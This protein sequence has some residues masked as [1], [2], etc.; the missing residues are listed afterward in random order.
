[1]TSSI[2]SS[3]AEI[4]A[5][6]IRLDPA[7]TFFEKPIAGLPPLKDTLW[8]RLLIHAHLALARETP[9][10]GPLLRLLL[11][12]QG[13]RLSVGE[14]ELGA[15]RHVPRLVARTICMS[16]MKERRQ[17]EVH[18]WF[19]RETSSQ[20][21]LCCDSSSLNSYEPCASSPRSA[22]RVEPKDLV[23]SQT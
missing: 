14:E 15:S 20:V 1:M 8:C 11:R 16:P 19:M 3:A 22:E 9:G 17:L 18:E 13:L 10:L 5:M 4:F 7:A 23:D 21:R 6:L 12:L 2:F